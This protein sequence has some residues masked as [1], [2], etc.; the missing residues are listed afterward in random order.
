MTK[1][2]SQGPHAWP[3]NEDSA[4]TKASAIQPLMGN[5]GG[6]EREHIGR[7]A[8]VEI[9]RAIVERKGPSCG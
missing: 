4:G 2:Q 5:N 6:G 8:D 9:N 7:H 3:K 1:G